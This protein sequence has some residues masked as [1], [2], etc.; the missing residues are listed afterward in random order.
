VRS[1]IDRLWET[2]RAAVSDRR[3]NVAMT[4]AL[5][6]FP[7]LLAVTGAVEVFSMSN[8]KSLLQAAADAGA[9]AGANKLSVASYDMQTDVTTAAVTAAKNQ[10][11]NTADP[12]AYTF[13][14]KIDQPNGQVTVDGQVAHKAF[15]GLI[16]I[17]DGIIHASATAE[18][19]QKTP[20]CILQTAGGAI[21]LSNTAQIRAP[22]CLIH[23]NQ[24]IDIAQT[25]MITADRTQA[26]GKVTGPANPAG[27]SGA[28]PIPD[29]FADMNLNPKGGCDLSLNILT[30]PVIKQDLTLAPGV[31]CLPIIAVGTAHIHLQPGEHYFVGL[32]SIGALGGL[33][34]NDD[35]TIDGDDV[36]LIFGPSQIF[37][38]TGHAKV[39]LT[40]RKTGPF[41][42]FLIATTRDN[43]NT[44]TISSDNVREL[45]GTIYIPN[46]TLDVT[47]QGAVAQDSDWSVIVAQSVKLS[48]SPTLVINTNY[49]GSGV[50]VPQGVGPG[51]GTV[52]KQ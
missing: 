4:V 17:G 50:P 8:Q 23:A 12:A 16:D 22:G 1:P 3:G 45:L 9:L 19:L 46:A 33:V 39:R 51:H 49:V 18:A 36:T 32:G 28:M 7:L 5:I 43:H 15:S 48:K 34:M 26:A 11:S 2:V 6:A 40:A 10:L 24:N 47:S 25:A 31:H 41:A 44:F 27:N 21:N 52:L 37:N 35:S 30:I 13:T 38:F 20:L 14:V 29:P 42:G